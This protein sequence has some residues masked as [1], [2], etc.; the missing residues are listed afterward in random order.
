MSPGIHAAHL[1]RRL[2]L[3]INDDIEPLLSEG[4]CSQNQLAKNNEPNEPEDEEVAS[5]N[6]S[7]KMMLGKV[8]S[9]FHRGPPEEFQ[10]G[11]DLILSR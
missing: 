5:C 6:F 8:N 1:D 2:S 9:A 4:R 11:V 7:K 3:W 10:E